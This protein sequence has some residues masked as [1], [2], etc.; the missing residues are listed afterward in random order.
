MH[1]DS[2]IASSAG[3][4]C[5]PGSDAGS[6]S[7]RQSTT[8]GRTTQRLTGRD[9]APKTG[10]QYTP[11]ETALPPSPAASISSVEHAE[12]TPFLP[13]IIVPR[14]RACRAWRNRVGSSG[15]RA[16]GSGCRASPRSSSSAPSST[17]CLIHTERDT[18]TCGQDSVHI[19]SK[20][21]L[22]RHIVRTAEK[23]DLSST[24]LAE[25]DLYTGTLQCAPVED[26]VPALSTTKSS[27]F[28]APARLEVLSN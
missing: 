23:D 13:C 24:G 17:A 20:P 21:G 7:S 19:T 8:Q 6:Y 16:S 2:A 1:D 11:T 25:S 26:N 4:G 18:Q 10:P 27:P 12:N 14:C 28:P 9:G 3:G 5:G 22:E 15:R